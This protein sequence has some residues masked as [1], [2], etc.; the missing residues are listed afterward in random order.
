MDPS[1]LA[2]LLMESPPN[3]LSPEQLAQILSILSQPNPSLDVTVASPNPVNPAPS[4]G[5]FA[6]AGSFQ[7]LLPPSPNHTPWAQH[8]LPSTSLSSGLPPAHESPKG[9]MKMSNYLP[10]S[11]I[12]CL[13][14]LT[15]SSQ[16]PEGEELPRDTVPLVVT[17]AIFALALLTRSPERIQQTWVSR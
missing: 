10:H 17:A 16:K 11:I 12:T 1:N 7:P 8:Q 5:S 4:G 6:V 13:Q 9:S 14:G 2:K 3:S 15:V